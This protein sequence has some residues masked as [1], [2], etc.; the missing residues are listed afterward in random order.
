M[1]K[2]V[3]KGAGCMC[4]CVEGGDEERTQYGTHKKRTWVCSRAKDKS[5]CPI[6]ILVPGD[7]D[8]PISASLGWIRLFSIKRVPDLGA[9]P[10][11]MLQAKAALSLSWTPAWSLMLG[12]SSFL[13]AGWDQVPCPDLGTSSGG[14]AVTWPRAAGLLV[15]PP[16]GGGKEA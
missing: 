3:E 15:C 6:H 4:V 1:V 7:G 8:S 5:C 16:G 12:L 2:G 11:L 9:I 14:K 10:L 13:T